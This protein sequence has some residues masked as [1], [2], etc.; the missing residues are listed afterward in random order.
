MVA[1]QISLLAVLAGI[2]II[3]LNQVK[4]EGLSGYELIERIH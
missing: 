4:A 1:C 3:H 2:F